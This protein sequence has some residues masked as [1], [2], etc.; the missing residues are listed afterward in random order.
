MR[1]MTSE[2]AEENKWSEAVAI[3]TVD[4]VNT[5]HHWYYSSLSLRLI[6]QQV[7]YITLVTCTK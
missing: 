7:S 3:E 6:G 2:V 5:S 1:Q 4:A